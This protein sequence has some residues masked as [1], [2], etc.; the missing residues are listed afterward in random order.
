M[1]YLIALAANPNVQSE[2]LPDVV[3]HLLPWLVS[4]VLMILL[5]K[6]LINHFWRVSE[7]NER[8]MRDC[9]LLEEKLDKIIQILERGPI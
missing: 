2:N 3:I 6:P 7:I 5:I 4:I 1:H 9:D 8:I